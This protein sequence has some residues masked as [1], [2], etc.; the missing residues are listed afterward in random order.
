[1]KRSAT[2]D[3][4]ERRRLSQPRGRVLLTLRACLEVNDLDLVQGL[5][6]HCAGEHGE[7]SEPRR[8]SF[9]DRHGNRFHLVTTE[10]RSLTVIT[11]D[12]DRP[13]PR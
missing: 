2:N 1:M 5:F 11:V 7:A 3:D 10:D 8:S 13:V 4:D 12:D 6:R 9:R